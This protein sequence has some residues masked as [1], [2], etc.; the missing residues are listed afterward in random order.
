MSRITKLPKNQSKI[1]MP[2]CK[3]IYE[4]MAV[5]TDDAGNYPFKGFRYEEDSQGHPADSNNV[6]FGR[7]VN[8]PDGRFPCVMIYVK[9]TA[10]SPIGFPNTDEWKPTIQ[11]IFYTLS[12][13][14]DDMSLHYHWLEELDRMIAMARHLNEVGG[15][16]LNDL[17]VQISRV[18]G[19]SFEWA[20]GDD[21]VIDEMT[22][23]IEVKIKKAGV[24]I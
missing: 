11:A 22:I 13:D 18:T 20:F 15:G 5:Y 3:R 12:Y 10:H 23:N 17:C 8:V 16:G 2:L 19:A 6:F 9:D 14:E 4:R 21:F 24:K 1:Y 7:R